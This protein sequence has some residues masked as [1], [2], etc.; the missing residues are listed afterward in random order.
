MRRSRSGHRGCGHERVGRAGGRVRVRIE[1]RRREDLAAQLVVALGEERG[2]AGTCRGLDEVGEQRLKEGADPGAGSEQDRLRDAGLAR[3]GAEELPA[4]ESEDIA[5]PE[6]EAGEDERRCVRGRDGSPSQRRKDSVPGPG[7]TVVA[8]TPELGG[9]EAE[10]GPNGGVRMGLFANLVEESV[11][12]G[13]CDEVGEERPP[14]GTS[15]AAA[16]QNLRDDGHTDSISPMRAV[17]M[18]PGARDADNTPR[19]RLCS[20][21]HRAAGPHQAHRAHAL[22]R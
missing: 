17:C 1:R 14:V 6:D 18:P 8:S 3:N 4:R 12:L 15:Q 5:T 2:E 9:G 22:G 13:G 7:S 16:S 19:S 21:S 10:R 11:E 20:P